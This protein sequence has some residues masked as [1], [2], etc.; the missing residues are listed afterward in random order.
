M[1]W[2]QYFVQGIEL[3]YFGIGTYFDIRDQELPI[4]FLTLFAGLGILCN[5]LWQYQ[6][7]KNV[8]IGGFVGATFLV[9]CWASKE[10][11][12]YGDGIGLL[13]LGIFEGAYG[14]I[15]IVFGAFL[16]S[17]IYG[18]WKLIGLKKSGGDTMPFFPFLFM[19][20]LGVKLL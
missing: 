3:L 20:F 17:G 9:I 19:A 11:I 10:A 14:M 15:P 18:L 5:I 16:F 6:S 2:E 13:T 8:V 4:P 7:L 12:G 1:N